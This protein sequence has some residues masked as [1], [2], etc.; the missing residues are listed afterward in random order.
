MVDILFYMPL[1]PLTPKAEKSE[2]R[3][4]RDYKHAIL[5]IK[6]RY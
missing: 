1:I 5:K 3:L 4:S 6:D 2:F